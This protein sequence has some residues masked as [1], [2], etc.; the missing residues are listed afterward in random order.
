MLI[1]FD[2][3]IND[4]L[5][6]LQQEQYFRSL[7]FWLDL[8]GSFELNNHIPSE[9][10]AIAKSPNVT[11]TI[12]EIGKIIKRDSLRYFLKCHMSR[13]DCKRYI[14]LILVQNEHEIE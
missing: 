10:G 1:L 4:I 12:K 13:I 9:L 6:N 11:E 14:L 2:S 5:D 8:Y 3:P 7:L